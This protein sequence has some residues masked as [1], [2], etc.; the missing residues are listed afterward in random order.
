MN[1][2][3]SAN[4]HQQKRARDEEI[5]EEIRRRSMVVGRHLPESARG[6]RSSHPETTPPHSRTPTPPV[7][8]N[9]TLDQTS[10]SPGTP[11]PWSR[12]NTPPPRPSMTPHHGRLRDDQ[13]TVQPGPSWSEDWRRYEDPEDHS[14]D[15]PPTRKRQKKTRT[16]QKE[17][18]VSLLTA[19]IERNTE[20]V[21]QQHRE[22][23]GLL[24]RT[25]QAQQKMFNDLMGALR[26]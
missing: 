5:G 15:N 19:A 21:E 22:N 24:E 17:D 20:V 4:D 23:Q 1:C 3:N 18:P 7:G 9:P 10:N 14:K 11:I 12:S 2:G 13:K 26:D 25:T 16:R 8:F 6:M